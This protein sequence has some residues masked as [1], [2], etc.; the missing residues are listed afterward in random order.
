[1]K[2]ELISDIRRI[3]FNAICIFSLL[4]LL[5]TAFIAWYFFVEFKT[6]RLSTIAALTGQI[7]LKDLRLVDRGSPSAISSRLKPAITEMMQVFP[8]DFSAGFYSRR[9][10]QVVVIVSQT[11]DSRVIGKK[12]P[13]ETPGRRSW[14]RLTPQYGLH[15]IQ[16]RHGWVLNCDYPLTSGGVVIGHSFASVPISCV[17]GNF[18]YLFG[19][20]ALSIL[21][22]G[23]LA[24]VGSRHSTRKLEGNFHRLLR[25]NEQVP[26]D[27]PGGE[28]TLP[29]DYHELDRMA[30]RNRQALGALARAEEQRR[31][32]LAN[33][34]WGYALIDSHGRLLDLNQSGARLLSLKYPIKLGQ[35]LESMGI[36]ELPL[37]KTIRE[38]QQL[39]KEFRFTDPANGTTRFYYACC[40]PIRLP[41]GEIGATAWFMDITDRRRTEETIRSSQ[42]YLANVLNSIA[43]SFYTLDRQW[44]FTQINQGAAKLFFGPAIKPV[45]GENIWERFPKLVG[46]ELY[47]EFHRAIRDNVPVEL[48]HEL[49]YQPGH[50]L[51]IHAYPNEAGLSVFLREITARKK[52][53][54]ELTSSRQSILDIIESITDGFFALD[55]RWRFTYINQAAEHQVGMTAERLL[56]QDIWQAF[57]ELSPA[58]AAAFR[59]AMVEASVTSFESPD[60]GQWCQFHVYPSRSGLSVFFH[61][62]DERKQLEATRDRLALIVESSDDAIISTDTQGVILSWNRGAAKIYGYEPAEVIGRPLIV[63]QPPELIGEFRENLRAVETGRAVEL[64][65]TVRVHRDGSRLLVSIKLTAIRDQSGAVIGMCA[66]HRDVTQQK[67]DRQ[68]LAAERERL[69]VTLRSIS[70]AVIATD[71][72]GRV[73][74]MNA[75]AE[76]LTGYVMAE[77]VGR[78]LEKVFRI[79]NER[80]GAPLGFSECYERS[81]AVLV[82]KE[83]DER[84]IAV[85]CAPIRDAVNEY[86]TVLT[87]EDITDRLRTEQELLKTQ[88]LESLGTLAG[89]IA[90]DFN[91]LLAA[92]LANLQLIQMKLEKGQDIQSYLRDTIETTRKASGLTKQLLSFAKESN[93]VRQPISLTELV[94]TAT[95]FALRGSKIKARF[96][97][98]PDLLPAEV[99]QSQINQVIYNLIINAKQAMPK[100]GV[101][102]IRAANVILPPSGIYRPGTYVRLTFQDQ[103]V[104]I[105]KE[106]LPKIFDPFFTTKPDGTGLG[107][108]TSYSII[109]KH[110]GY[111]EVQSELGVGTTFQIYLPAADD[112]EVAAETRYETA[113]AGS[114]LKI[115]LMD[116]E[117]MILNRVGEMLGYYGHQVTFARDGAETVALYRQAWQAGKPF[118]VVIL[119]LT[120]PGGLG[121][122]ETLPLLREVNPGVKAVVSSGYANDP[123]LADFRQYGFQGV[124]SKPYKV[125]E[126]QMVLKQVANG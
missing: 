2:N 118:D 107:L 74:L 110:N 122:Q 22:S 13:L 37:R 24:W 90:H 34:P 71:Q 108:A 69:L 35:T 106:H 79:L 82:T 28:E 59:Q 11:P 67:A 102:D 78:P 96:H 65:E 61:N 20:L 123:L 56:H 94:Q 114:R 75:K 89:G 125:D 97:L 25:L 14:E 124:V 63:I 86:G 15:W 111:I 40:C 83:L 62:I 50:W 104:G 8:K 5:I 1:M 51:E 53:E 81:N 73:M 21:F 17:L 101:I 42:Q 85:Q 120:V 109:N 31:Q 12:L 10:D 91:N 43:D 92:I 100:G 41:A 112:A 84:L 19:G 116:D 121:A 77:V 9:L 16:R 29:F 52:A 39:T 55:R 47:Q 36:V 103:G 88:K 7:V 48:E 115:L 87:F 70:E 23:I 64:C 49:V 105:A 30:R 4:S 93:P 45:L 68:N 3:P 95:Q 99:D 26:E 72:N 32:I 76:E 54:A 117:E 44:R 58:T 126:L 38:Q 98:A 113:S 46:N 60:L 6:T 57:P 66:I 18:L 33:C 27:E 80:T 119:D